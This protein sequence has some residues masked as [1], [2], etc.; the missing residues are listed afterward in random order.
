MGGVGYYANL[1]RG[2]YTPSYRTR[3]SGIDKDYQAYIDEC[4]LIGAPEAM[5]YDVWQEVQDAFG[6][7]ND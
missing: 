2:I 7:E 6:F 5:P 3:Y 4:A 1:G